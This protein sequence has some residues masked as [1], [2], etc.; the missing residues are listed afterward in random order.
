MEAAQVQKIVVKPG[1][2]VK[3]RCQQ[4]GLVKEV[5]PQNLAALKREIQVRCVCSA[6]FPVQFEYRKFY[7]K[8]TNLEGIYQKRLGGSEGCSLALRRKKANC[9][10]LNLSMHGAGFSVLGWHMLQAGDSLLLGFALDDHGN[11]WIEKRCVVR[12]VAENYVGVEF[13][14]P[15]NADKNFGFYLLP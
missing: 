8:Q 3:I 12:V 5:P 14:E 11:T 9:R 4:C 13:D 6:I 7:R 1:S 2:A 15:A 10:V